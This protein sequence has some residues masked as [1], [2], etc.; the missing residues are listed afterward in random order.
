[1]VARFKNELGDATIVIA[2]GGQIH[3]ISDHT[4]AIDHIESWLTLEGMRVIWELNR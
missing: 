4:N 3:R 1:M 2:T